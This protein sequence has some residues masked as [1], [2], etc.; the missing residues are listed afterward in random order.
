[1]P[2]FAYRALSASGRGQ[3]GV[4][5]AESLRVAWQRLRALGVYPTELREE[6]G[7]APGRVATRELAAGFRALA[8]LVG[9]GVPVAEALVAVAEES[10]GSLARAL[11]HAHARV[12]EG[13]PLATAL[14]ESPR[15]FPALAC[16]LVAA[17]ETSGALPAVLVRLA[18][19]TE[20]TAA[21]RARLRAALG[22]PVVM[23]CATVAMLVFL[24]AWVVPQ[25]TSLFAE[26]GAPLPLPTRA[27]VAV[28]RWSWLLLPAL[29]LAV[30]MLRGG[31]WM[32]LPLVGAIARRAAAARL[33]RTL[34]TLLAGGIPLEAALGIA[35]AGAGRAP[36]GGAILAARDAVRR[37]EALAPAL[38]A[39][40]LFPS[41][42]V[43]LVAAG[44]RGGT[45]AGSL[46]RAAAAEETEL[47]AAVGGLVALVEPVL[48]LVMGGVVLVLVL[49]IL[50]PLLELNTLVR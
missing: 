12:R 44:E 3:S 29:A 23:A 31:G 30:W 11:T 43:R 49:G 15:V 50:L 33:A 21:T 9:A 40:G 20:A 18:E 1:M 6:G 13:V 16:D 19:H 27:L 48:V 41:L 34:A 8:T 47:E 10:D 37:G 24:L 35:A 45:L 25:V 26:S 38:A 2:V 32:R 17:G 7:A 22:Y 46:E 28:A 39:S 42:L 5:E 4:I 14:A 36:L